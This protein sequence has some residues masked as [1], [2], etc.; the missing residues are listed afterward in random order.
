MRGEIANYFFFFEKRRENRW[1]IIKPTFCKITQTMEALCLL[2][3]SV[4]WKKMHFQNQ[5]ARLWASLVFPPSRLC[6]IL[7]FFFLQFIGTWISYWLYLCHFFSLSNR[8]FRSRC[9]ARTV[10]WLTGAELPQNR[11]NA[12]IHPLS[13]YHLEY[14]YVVMISCGHKFPL[15]SGS[16]IL[17]NTIYADWFQINKKVGLL[18]CKNLANP[19]FF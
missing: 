15:W 3:P 13:K 11:E 17:P 9:I 18:L 7:R 6:V 1:E 5:Y 4:Y 19:R 10:S 14:Y 16:A 2:M 8:N 12:E